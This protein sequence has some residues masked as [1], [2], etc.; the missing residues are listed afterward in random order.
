M[1]IELILGGRFQGKL[2]FILERG[3][4]SLADVADETV[5][6]QWLHKPVLNRLHRLVFR[7]LQEGGDPQ[8][9]L[10]DVLRRN[11]DAIVLCNEIGCGVVPV[12]ALERRYR[13]TVGHLCC[14]LARRAGRVIRIQC[15]LPMTLKG[16]AL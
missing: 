3:G 1:S 16:E 12:G 15:G 13:E 9:F 10:E 2:E 11:P 8:E 5:P 7:L 6:E 14:D 4:F